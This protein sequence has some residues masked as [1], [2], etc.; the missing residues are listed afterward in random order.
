MIG[1]PDGEIASRPAE[2]SKLERIHS[3][4]RHKLYLG[5]MDGVNIVAKVTAAELPLPRAVAPLRREYELLRKL[6]LPVS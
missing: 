3:G 5:S 1:R 6:D 2:T 4:P